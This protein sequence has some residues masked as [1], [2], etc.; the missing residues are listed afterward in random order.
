[1]DIRWK[2]QMQTHIKSQLLKSVKHSRTW[3]HLN[4]EFDTPAWV[5]RMISMVWTFSS[6]ESHLA[7][8]GELGRKMT[9]G[10]KTIKVN[11]VQTM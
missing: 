10:T 2:L 7:S 6:V 11:M 8:S 4:V 1:M 9:S 3:D 5:S